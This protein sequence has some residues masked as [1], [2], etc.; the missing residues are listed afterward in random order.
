[1]QASPQWQRLRSGGDFE[2][3]RGDLIST[4]EWRLDRDRAQSGD[5]GSGRG[6]TSDDSLSGSGARHGSH[7]SSRS[8]DSADALQEREE[9]EREE[10]EERREGRRE[11]RE[12]RDIMKRISSGFQ[13]ARGL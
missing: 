6:A 4:V 11:E 10:R 7:G 12:D 3:F 13:W 5:E 2:W 1:L 8:V 9:E